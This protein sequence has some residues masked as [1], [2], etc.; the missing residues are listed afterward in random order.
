MNTQSKSSNK[1]KTVLR[2]LS[3]A[4]AI[5]FAFCFMLFVYEPMMLYATHQPDLWFDFPLMARP[6]LLSLIMFFI[7]SVVVFTVLFFIIRL[8]VKEKSAAVYGI[9]ELSVFG[10]LFLTFLQGNIFAIFLPALDGAEIDWKSIRIYDLITLAAA[11]VIGGILIFL[12]VKFGIKR[13]VKYSKI[14]SL[15]F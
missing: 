6:I 4:Y 3:P 2:E 1:F 5:A 14:F 10:L 8:L 11:L 15:G 13:T 12:A 9:M 7:G